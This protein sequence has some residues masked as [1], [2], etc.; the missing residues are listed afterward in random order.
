MPVAARSWRG[1]RSAETECGRRVPE[2]VGAGGQRVGETGGGSQSTLLAFTGSTRIPKFFSN[3]QLLD[4]EANHQRG[5]PR[6]YLP[7][8]PLPHP[9]SRTSPPHFLPLRSAVSFKPLHLFM[10]L[11][12]ISLAV[13]ELKRHLVVRTVINSLIPLPLSLTLLSYLPLF[14]PSS[15]RRGPFSSCTNA[16]TNVCGPCDSFYSTFPFFFLFLHLPS[17]NSLHCF[18]SLCLCFPPAH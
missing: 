8:P 9:N 11:F 12:I 6:A 14:I 17:N 4:V 5:S 18:H 1:A 2:R 7:Y 3:L 15:H 13:S 10:C 16:L